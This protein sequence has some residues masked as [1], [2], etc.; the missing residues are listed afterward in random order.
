MISVLLIFRTKLAAFISKS[1]SHLCWK[2]KQ[3]ISRISVLFQFAP[4]FIEAQMCSSTY[5]EYFSLG[6]YSKLMYKLAVHWWCAPISHNIKT[7]MVQC[8][9][10]KPSVLVLCILTH[11]VILLNPF[12]A[13]GALW[14][15]FVI[16]HP[17]C[18]FVTMLLD[19]FQH[20]LTGGWCLGHGKTQ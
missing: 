18:W 16:F 14:Q 4:L 20:N 1:N 19:G 5:F 10:G 12:M 17:V 7:I 2:I 11:T 6:L 8:W 9:S 3:E 13:R 15:V